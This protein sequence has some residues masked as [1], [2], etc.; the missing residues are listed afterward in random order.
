[1]RIFVYNV[2]HTDMSTQE[3]RSLR[4]EANKIASILEGNK[5]TKEDAIGF[6]RMSGLTFSTK[7]FIVGYA[8][9]NK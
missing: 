5:L 1:M 8:K 2:T 3:L 9:S 4:E 6:L 7:E